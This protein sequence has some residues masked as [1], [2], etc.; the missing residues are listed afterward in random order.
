MAEYDGAA[1][2]KENNPDEMNIKL[3]TAECV[4]QLIGS[5]DATASSNKDIQ[6]LVNGVLSKE[7]TIFIQLSTVSILEGKSRKQESLKEMQQTLEKKDQALKYLQAKLDCARRSDKVSKDLLAR[8]KKKG[9]YIATLMGSEKAAKEIS[10]KQQLV[11]KSLLAL[12]QKEKKIKFI[13]GS[14]S[15]VYRRTEP[16]PM[17]RDDS[18]PPSFICLS[19]LR[20]SSCSFRTY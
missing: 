13:T 10:I 2:D 4:E 16:S 9:D 3:S 18:L 1:V 20:T 8:Q 17:V 5:L 12:G 11:A 19:A 7:T 6:L 14:H 15:I